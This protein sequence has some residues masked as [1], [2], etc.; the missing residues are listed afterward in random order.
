M[1]D[2]DPRDSIVGLTDKA[3]PLRPLYGSHSPQ[4]LQADRLVGD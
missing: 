1:D 3:R 2:S 4:G